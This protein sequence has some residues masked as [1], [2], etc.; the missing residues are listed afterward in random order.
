MTKKTYCDRCGKEI[1]KEDIEI[2]MGDNFD[3]EIFSKFINNDKFAF[4]E[5][6]KDLF[7]NNFDL[8]KKCEKEFLNIIKENNQRLMDYV[9]KK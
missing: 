7:K 8:C 4:I 2:K 1:K 6:T 5:Q 3:P 9:N